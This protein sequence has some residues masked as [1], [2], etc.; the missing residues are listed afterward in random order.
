MTRRND[1]GIL[2]YARNFRKRNGYRHSHMSIRME[3]V[4]ACLVRPARLTLQMQC[5]RSRQL[6]CMSLY[7]RTAWRVRGWR[8]PVAGHRRFESVGNLDKQISIPQ[9]LNLCE[10]FVHRLMTGA[11]AP[12]PFLILHKA[13]GTC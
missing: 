13:A 10:F 7:H 2:H 6:A 5:A 4:T 9:D 12:W 8:Q 11:I 3:A 1:F